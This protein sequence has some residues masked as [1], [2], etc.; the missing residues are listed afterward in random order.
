[1]SDTKY[2]PTVPASG[3]NAGPLGLLAG[4]LG[5][6]GLGKGDFVWR[7]ILLGSMSGLMAIFGAGR[8]TPQ[9]YCGGAWLWF[10][11]KFCISSLHIVMAV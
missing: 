7:D 3:S 5:L 6:C 2:K 11:G 8:G 10:F 9:N 1:M 4:K